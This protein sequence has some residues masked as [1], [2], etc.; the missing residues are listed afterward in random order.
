MTARNTFRRRWF[1]PL[2]EITTL[3][4]VLMTASG[5]FRP[6]RIFLLASTALLARADSGDSFLGTW[7]GSYRAESGERGPFLMQVVPLGSSRHLLWVRMGEHGSRY[8]IPGVGEKGK[9]RFSGRFQYASGTDEAAYDLTGEIAGDAASGKFASSELNGTIELKKRR[10]ATQSQEPPAGAIVLYR[11]STDLWRRRDGTAPDWIV[12]PD[13]SLEA[14][15]SDIETRQSFA[16]LSLHL[17]FL[18][19]LEA[20][21]R[22]Q[23]RGN[24]G[25]VVGGACEVH[26][27]DSFAREPTKDSCGAILGAAAP[28]TE[29]C[30]PPLEWQVFDITLHA[31]QTDAGGR[32]IQPAE[33][34]VALNGVV[35]HERWRLA[36][37]RGAPI[38]LRAGGSPIRFRNIWIQLRGE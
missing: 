35:L 3:A 33:I 11:G 2:A 13:G 31:P 10:Y 18:L 23:Q 37:C 20:E 24:G 9:L 21:A 12:R 14:G 22:G 30:L 25:V 5:S 17:E 32:Q 15:G 19:P 26:I 16:S 28:R 27:L 4:R 1:W 8:E 6:C 7:E 36:E 29:A 34:T 38:R